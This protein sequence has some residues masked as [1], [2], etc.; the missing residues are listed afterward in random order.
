M[1]QA[2]IR[3]PRAVDLVFGVLAIATAI[4]G[5][6]VALT[7]RAGGDDL[8]SWCTIA[9]QDIGYGDTTLVTTPQIGPIWCP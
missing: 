8:A 2:A 9:A 6:G 4:A 1:A 3:S 5:T 7:E